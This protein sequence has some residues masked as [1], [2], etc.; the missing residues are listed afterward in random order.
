MIG[1]AYTSSV[2]YYD[3]QEKRQKFKSRPCLIIGQADPGDYVILPI[4]SV[5]DKSKI[6]PVYDIPLNCSI[7]TF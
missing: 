4:S 2:P 6:D 5:S 3:R 1:K 7:F